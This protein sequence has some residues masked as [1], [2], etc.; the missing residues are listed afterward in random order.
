MTEWASRFSSGN[1]EAV[2]AAAKLVGKPRARARST[3]AGRPPQHTRSPRARPRLPFYPVHCPC[4]RCPSGLVRAPAHPS[5]LCAHAQPFAVRTRTGPLGSREGGRVQRPHK[6]LKHR[7]C[8][9]LGG[10]AQA[11]TYLQGTKLGLK[12]RSMRRGGGTAATLK[13]WG[14]GLGGPNGRE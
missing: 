7:P 8:R 11:H 13:G 4:F 6:I 10:S 5:A 14:R 12:P 1:K 3:S 9:A 2:A